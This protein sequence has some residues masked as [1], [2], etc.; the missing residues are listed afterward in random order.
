MLKT[1][2]S[3]KLEILLKVY[4]LNLLKFFQNVHEE[5]MLNFVLKSLINISDFLP[6]FPVSEQ[7]TYYFTSVMD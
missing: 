7:I 6:A 2:K 4:I 1:I 3:K 5:E